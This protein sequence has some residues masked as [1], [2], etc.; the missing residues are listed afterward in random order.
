[1][2]NAIAK[3][4][5][6]SNQVVSYLLLCDGS[7]FSVTRLVWSLPFFLWILNKGA[8]N[9]ENLTASTHVFNVSHLNNDN[10]PFLCK[11]IGWHCYLGKAKHQLITLPDNIAMW[12]DQMINNCI[13][14]YLNFPSGY[15]PNAIDSMITPDG[16][17]VVITYIWPRAMTNPMAPQR[18]NPGACE[19]LQYSD[20]HVRIAAFATNV[21]YFYELNDL[22]VG[23]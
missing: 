11:V 21:S 17:E 2:R 7:L 10:K 23:Q 8:I 12:E 22:P 4:R 5:I 6:A 13:I 14:A 9:Q 20:V 15:S 18:M 3:Y 1:M 19:T 16:K